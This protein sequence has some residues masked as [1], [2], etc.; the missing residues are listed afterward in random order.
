MTF[1]DGEIL[2][3]MV[4]KVVACAS[5]IELKMA[6]TTARLSRNPGC[7]H[8]TKE[9]EAVAYNAATVIWQGKFYPAN[10]LLSAELKRRFNQE[11]TTLAVNQ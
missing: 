3:D 7:F 8:K 10:D 2:E 11:I 4:H 9:P 5:E 6:D 1:Q